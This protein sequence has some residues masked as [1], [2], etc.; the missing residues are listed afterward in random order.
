[1]NMNINNKNLLRFVSMG[2]MAIA[3]MYENAAVKAAPLGKR[4]TDA[5][6]PDPNELAFLKEANDTLSVFFDV[7]DR[8]KGGFKVNYGTTY[9]M[10]LRTDGGNLTGTTQRDCG[11]NPLDEVSKKHLYSVVSGM[12]E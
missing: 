4:A 3:A 10:N 8:V 11:P 9:V 1:M 7:A 12:N 2:A 5:G 6:E